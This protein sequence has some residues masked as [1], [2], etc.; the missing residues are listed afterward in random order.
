MEPGCVFSPLKPA[1]FNALQRIRQFDV[2]LYV[3]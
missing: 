3:S 1:V 2:L